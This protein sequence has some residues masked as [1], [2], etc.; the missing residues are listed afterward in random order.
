MWGRK[1]A[2][3]FRTVVIAAFVCSAF[4][5]TGSVAQ[6][7]P[8]VQS[9]L[10]AI[11]GQS[12]TQTPTSQQT[13]QVPTTPSQSTIAPT[14]A[15]AT[16]AVPQPPSQLEQLF[17][18]RAGKTLSQFGYDVLGVGSSI[19]VTQIGGL[20]DSYILGPGDQVN[21]VLRGHENSAYTAT[22][23]RDGR[24]ILPELEPIAAAG[25]TFGDVRHEILQ[26][27]TKTLMGTRGYISIG[28]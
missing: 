16:P 23:D 6:T 1:F 17:S 24:L 9:I 15:P 7:S 28:T 19:P 8:D 27:I 22:V 26:R 20:Q 11:G 14:V 25:R 5:L 13:P 18:Q 12:P 10:S 3:A 21:V 4:G 2:A